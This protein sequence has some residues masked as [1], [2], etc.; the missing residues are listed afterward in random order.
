MRYSIFTL[1]IVASIFL[2]QCCS[3]ATNL[4][5]QA[6]SAVMGESSVVDK[7]TGRIFWE[8]GSSSTLAESITPK[9]RSMI[10]ISHAKATLLTGLLLLAA[11]G[12]ISKVLRDA[13]LGFLVPDVPR[14]ILQK[15]ILLLTRI[16]LLLPKFPRWF[17]LFVFILYLLEAYMCSTHKYLTY[18]VDDAESLVDQLRERFPIVEWNVRSFHYENFLM[19]ILKKLIHHSHQSDHLAPSFPSFWHWKCVTRTAQGLYTYTSCKDRTVSGVWKR[20]PVRQQQS[21]RNVPLTKIVVTKTLLLRDAKA[22]QDYFRQQRLFLSKEH[23]DEYAEFSTNVHVDGFQPRILA[24]SDTAGVYRIL[25]QPFMF[26]FFTCLGFTVPYRRW[27]S[28]HCDEIRVRI[29]KETSA[30][31]YQAITGRMLFNS[32]PSAKVGKEP[33]SSYRSTI[34]DLN[35]TEFVTRHPDSANDPTEEMVLTS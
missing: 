18:A 8:G 24:V 1:F 20:A 27:L 4:G 15:A 13:L 23:S 17:V 5:L 32:S 34:Q 16:S 2:L 30:D 29:V 26:W 35:N 33:S 14:S 22:R 11:V 28:S 12:A 6:A 25:L 19:T 9:L 10:G 3:V 7:E 21:T 31:P